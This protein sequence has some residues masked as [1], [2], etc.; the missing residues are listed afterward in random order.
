MKIKYIIEI[1]KQIFS[2][3]KHI[4]CFIYKVFSY[5]KGWDGVILTLSKNKA[6]KYISEKTAQKASLVYNGKI[7]KI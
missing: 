2:S 7:I 1:K 3:N 5:K 6:H 4:T